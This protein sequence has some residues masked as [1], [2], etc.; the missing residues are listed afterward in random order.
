[1]NLEDELTVLVRQFAEHQVG[2]EEMKTCGAYYHASG[3]VVS[4]RA[5]NPISKQ[6]NIEIANELIDLL[7]RQ[8]Y[9]DFELDTL[10]PAGRGFSLL[11][12]N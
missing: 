11:N 7:C 10:D 6:E 12:E 9:G 8:G 4:Y 2:L 5:K 1:M 3:L